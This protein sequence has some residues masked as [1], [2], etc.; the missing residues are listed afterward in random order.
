MSDYQKREALLVEALT[1]LLAA[2]AMRASCQ[3]GM[4]ERCKCVPCATKR[5]RVALGW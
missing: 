1:D 5:A 4:V 2:H 3:A